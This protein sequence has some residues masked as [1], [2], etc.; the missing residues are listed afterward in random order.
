MM[1]CRLG[2]RWKKF[3]K[4][5][6]GLQK[7]LRRREEIVIWRFKRRLSRNQMAKDLKDKQVQELRIFR[8]GY[9]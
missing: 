7:R 9:I 2:L 4:H 8:K 5:Q 6:L 1:F 3:K